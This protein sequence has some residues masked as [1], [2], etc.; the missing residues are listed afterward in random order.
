[1]LFSVPCLLGLGCQSDLS[2]TP[3]LLTGPLITSYNPRIPVQALG[4]SA[5]SGV[6][7]RAHKS[8]KLLGRRTLTPI[9]GK[10]GLRINSE[11]W[12]HRESLFMF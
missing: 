3:G 1:M 7:G 2:V 10:N 11:T 5:L 8:L 9:P 4:S 12:G 6:P